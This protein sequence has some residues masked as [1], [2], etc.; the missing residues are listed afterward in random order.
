MT[1]CLPV[2]L[3]SLFCGFVGERWH[4]KLFLAK[5]CSIN[6]LQERSFSKWTNWQLLYLQ[7]VNWCCHGNRITFSVLS[8]HIWLYS[9]TEIRLGIFFKSWI[10]EKMASLREMKNDLHLQPISENSHWWTNH[11]VSLSI[12][13][14]GER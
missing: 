9:R 13:E 11:L 4:A 5:C 1:V 14:V 8:L 7:N 3:I 10:K 2:S 12:W 6:S